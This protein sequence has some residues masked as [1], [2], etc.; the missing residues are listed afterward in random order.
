MLADGLGQPGSAIGFG[1]VDGHAQSVPASGLG[2]GLFQVLSAAG[3]QHHP[4]A[5][6]DRPD[7]ERPADS[8]RGAE[9]QHTRTGQGVRTH[10]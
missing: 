10:I 7:G 8:R 3:G 4:R 5:V 2:P 6:L 1:Q 9:H